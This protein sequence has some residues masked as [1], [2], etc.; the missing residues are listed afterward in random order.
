MPSADVY[1]PI[2]SAILVLVEEIKECLETEFLIL[3]TQ[4]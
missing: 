4:Q 1:L 3:A 2:N